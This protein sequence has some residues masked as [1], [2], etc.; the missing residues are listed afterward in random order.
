MP[1]VVYVVGTAT[2]RYIVQA[3]MWIRIQIESVFSN[4][5]KNDKLEEKGVRLKTKIQHS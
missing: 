1:T 4:L 2:V 5:V 3:V